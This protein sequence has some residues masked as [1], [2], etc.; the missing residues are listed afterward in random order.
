MVM[1][2]RAVVAIGVARGGKGWIFTHD[3]ANVSLF[4]QQ[5]LVL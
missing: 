4:T 5:A 1:R 2:L 3:A